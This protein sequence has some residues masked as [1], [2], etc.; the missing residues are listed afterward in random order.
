MLTLWS[1]CRADKRTGAVMEMRCLLISVT[2]MT[3]APTSGRGMGNAYDRTDSAGTVF[4]A[5]GDYVDET[6]AKR[7]HSHTFCADGG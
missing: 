2:Y 1:V 3:D 4:F 5:V 7:V 6:W